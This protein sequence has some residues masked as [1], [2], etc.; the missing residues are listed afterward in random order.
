LSGRF[1][2]KATVTILQSHVP[3]TRFSKK[4][5]SNYDNG[6]PQHS[7]PVA[8]GNPPCI[9]PASQSG[10]THRNPT[11]PDEHPPWGSVE[12]EQA[13]RHQRPLQRVLADF[14]TDL[15]TLDGMANGHDTR[16]IW[17]RTNPPDLASALLGGTPTAREH[18]TAERNGAMNRFSTI[19]AQRATRQS[20]LTNDETRTF[21]PSQGTGCYVPK[22]NTAVEEATCRCGTTPN[23]V[24]PKDHNISHPSKISPALPSL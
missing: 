23:F 8:R 19:A 15:S 7:S 18:S 3:R 17:I 13:P 20:C 14:R 22:T 1:I 10:Y 24:P 4:H 9:I 11:R 5:P 6:G 16:P 21:Y 12:Q 2:R